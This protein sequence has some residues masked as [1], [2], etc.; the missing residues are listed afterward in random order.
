MH[1]QT[2]FYAA[3]RVHNGLDDELEIVEVAVLAR[4]D[5]FPVPLIDIDRMDVVKLFVA[6][7]GVHIGIQAVSD[8][9]V[10]FFECQTLPFGKRMHHLRVCS[11]GRHIKAHRAFVAV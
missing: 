2:V 4:D 7:D 8:R 10:V 1:I 11:D 5:L 6:A 9:K 3:D